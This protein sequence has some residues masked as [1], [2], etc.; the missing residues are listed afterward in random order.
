MTDGIEMRLVAGEDEKAADL[1]P[2]ACL[3]DFDPPLPG[4]APQ[5]LVRA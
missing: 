2:R 4:D 1:R 5:A 3:R